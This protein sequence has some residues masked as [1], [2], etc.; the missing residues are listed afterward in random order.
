M[1]KKVSSVDKCLHLVRFVRASQRPDGF[2]CQALAS[3]VLGSSLVVSTTS[4][5]SVHWDSQ[6][7]GMA[8]PPV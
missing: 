5:A 4:T 8:R 2:L 1:C 7:G 3:R 6:S